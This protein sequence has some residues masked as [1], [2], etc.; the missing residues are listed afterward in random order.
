MSAQVSKL[1]SSAWYHLRNIQL[2]RKYL[3]QEATETIIH[4]FVSSKLDLNNGL[5]YKLLKKEIMRLQ[6]V[7]NVAARIVVRATRFTS[8]KPIL[9]QLHWLP[10]D[11]RIIYKILLL[12]FKCINNMAPIYLKELLRI[13]RTQ[14]TLRHNTGIFL[15]IPRTKTNWGERSFSVAGPH[16]WNKLPYKLRKHTSIA[17]FKKDLKSY[18]FKN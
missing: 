8:A 13:K 17:G 16:L 5:L 11:K 9:H 10:I 1:V 18:L 12:T 2:I 15:I 7:Q 3:T 4:A 14:R 6:K